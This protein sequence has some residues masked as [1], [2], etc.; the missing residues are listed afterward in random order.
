MSINSVQ[1]GASTA[2]QAEADDLAEVAGGDQDL[3]ALQ[4][5][6]DTELEQQL[7]PYCALVQRF[8]GS[9]HLLTAPS[10]LQASALLCLSK[11]MCISAPLAESSLQL[12]FSLVSKRCAR[13]HLVLPLRCCRAHSLFRCCLCAAVS[14]QAHVHLRAAV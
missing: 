4:E 7:A 6:L 1:E 14:Q 5:D 12:L 9:P 11:L 3:D 13:S 2:K 8:C 10:T